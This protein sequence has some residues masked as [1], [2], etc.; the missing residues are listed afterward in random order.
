MGSSQIQ[1]TSALQKEPSEKNYQLSDEELKLDC[2]K[3]TGRTQVRIMA[4]R[5]ADLKET[6]SAAS[7]TLGFLAAT[8]HG[9]NSANNSTSSLSNDRLILEAYNA[10]LA[11]MGCKS[12][13]L[14]KEL[15][16]RPSAPT[17]EPSIT[18]KSN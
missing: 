8:F 1:N 14:D 9:S 6:P 13:D 11:D 17:P 15:A 16:N 4:S 10:R 2:K 3:L 12:F 5:G 18:G 7:Q